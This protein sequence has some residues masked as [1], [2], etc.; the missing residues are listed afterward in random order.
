M[1]S[2]YLQEGFTH[3]LCMAFRKQNCYYVWKTLVDE[4]V[5]VSWYIHVFYSGI[6]KNKSV[7]QFMSDLFSKKKYEKIL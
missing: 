3:I 2:N 7:K 4:A 6:V 1:Y 5:D